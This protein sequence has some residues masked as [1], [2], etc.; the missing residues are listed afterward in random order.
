MPLIESQPDA[1]ART[2]ARSLFDLVDA[3]G[4]RGAIET[5][6]GQLE[7]ILELARQDARF[8]EF[9]ASRVVPAGQRSES[10]QRIFGNRADPLVVNFLRVLNDKGRLSHLPAIV[11]SFDALAQEKF[12]RIEVDVFTAEPLTSEGLSAIKNKLASSLGKDIVLHPYTDGAMIG[13]VKF[14][15]GDQL[16]DASIAT[17]LRHMRDTLDGPGASRLRARA[18]DVLGG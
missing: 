7:D 1:L 15:I 8:N 9:L 13:G 6:L 14:R 4:G 5:V 11:A 2:Y 16:V 12:G 17:Q 10:L 3:T 18:K